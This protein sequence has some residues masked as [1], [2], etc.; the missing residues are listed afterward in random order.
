RVGRKAK[1]GEGSKTR[2]QR[3]R[4]QP[5]G[6]PLIDKDSHPIPCQA[7]L[8]DRPSGEHDNFDKKDRGR[9]F[10]AE[11]EIYFC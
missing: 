6:I 4:H 10:V 2:S 5:L 3:V 1:T 9:R 11:K 8:L 7:V